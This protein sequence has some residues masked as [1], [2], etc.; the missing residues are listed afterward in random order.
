MKER[1]LSIVKQPT[2]QLDGPVV[3]P[4][5]TWGLPPA[6]VSRDSWE[7]CSAGEGEPQGLRN[8]PT[9][10]IVER[11]ESHTSYFYGTGAHSLI[12]KRTESL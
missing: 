12:K 7:V 5:H 8:P 3:E 6:S 1:R 10:L 2:Q 11:R 4:R 9:A